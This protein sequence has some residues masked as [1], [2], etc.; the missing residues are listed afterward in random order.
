MMTLLALAAGVRVS[1]LGEGKLRFSDGPRVA[2]ASAATL[3]PNAAGL[4][5][6][7]VG[8]PVLPEI[9]AQGT[10]TVAADGTV[11]IDGK[12][13]KRLQL[14]LPSGEVGYPGAAPFGTLKMG[15]ATP[16]T[17]AVKAGGKVTVAIHAKSEIE[18]DRVLLGDV[19]DLTGDPATVARLGAV[20]LGAVPNL[21]TFR[22]LTSWRVKSCLRDQGFREDAIALSFPPDTTVTRKGQTIDSDTLYAEATAKARELVP[23]GEVA[24]IAIPAA[25]LVPC[26]KYRIDTSA[27]LTGS[28]VTVKI[29]VTVDGQKA[30]TTTV[31]F[32][33]KAAAKGAGIK[34]G[35]AVRLTV[36]RNGAVIEIDVKAKSAGAVGDTI[37][38]VTAD[39][40]ALSATVTAPGAAEVKL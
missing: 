11:R 2:L 10:V 21:G 29:D 27:A 4:L 19:A 22:T 35:D 14:E 6:D 38:V 17:P 24:G 13:A 20:D 37:Q 30:A 36:I 5:A 33:V 32:N 26:G 18:G 39:G 28:L 7:A 3:A 40:A 1:V 16:T 12:A 8:R 9:K 15:N 25:L 34:A 23:G 31:K